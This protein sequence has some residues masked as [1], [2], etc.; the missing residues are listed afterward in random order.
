MLPVYLVL[1]HP[2]P[3]R[4]LIWHNISILRALSSPENT[5]AKH[6]PSSSSQM[7][8]LSA[9]PF[10]FLSRFHKFR[11]DYKLLPSPS[12]HINICPHDRHYTIGNGAY[13][14]PT[15]TGTTAPEIVTNTLLRLIPLTYHYPFILYKPVTSHP[16]PH[17][18]FLVIADNSIVRHWRW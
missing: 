13:S 9:L 18:N 6:N 7:Q 1:P 5:S 3:G 11:G 4:V 2:L 8:S 10:L 14:A 16:L 12:H 15:T 17:R